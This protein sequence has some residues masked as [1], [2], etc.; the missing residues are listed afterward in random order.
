MHSHLFARC[1]SFPFHS[2]QMLKSLSKCLPRLSRRT[3]TGYH[4]WTR[5]RTCCTCKR[6]LLSSA[7]SHTTSPPLT[8]FG[9]RR[10]VSLVRHALVNKLTR[11]H[12][13]LCVSVPVSVCLSVFVC[14]FVCE[15]MPIPPPPPKHRPRLKTACAAAGNYYSRRELS[16]KAEIYFRRALKLDNK[17]VI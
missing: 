14:L 11:Q 17:F 5:T 4:T 1:L 6:T 10:A 12:P 15:C 16:S 13:C 2:C 3:R 7:A 9:Q 8:S